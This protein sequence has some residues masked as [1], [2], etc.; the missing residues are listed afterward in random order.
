MSSITFEEGFD[1]LVREYTAATDGLI[2]ILTESQFAITHTPNLR[3]TIR[4]SGYR[5]T[6]VPTILVGAVRKTEALEERIFEY[7]RWW[8]RVDPDGYRDYLAP[9]ELY[10]NDNQAEA[11]GNEK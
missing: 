4:E 5:R 9:I 6:P 7:K 1:V 3:A 2:C 8:L 10:R 11:E